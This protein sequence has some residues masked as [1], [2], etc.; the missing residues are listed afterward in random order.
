MARLFNTT[1]NTKLKPPSAHPPPLTTY[2]PGTGRGLREVAASAWPEHGIRFLV[3][4]LIRG[5]VVHTP[6]DWPIVGPV[7]PVGPSVGLVS[8]L[9]GL[10]SPSVGLMSSLARCHSFGILSSTS[11]RNERGAPI[12]WVASDPRS[13]LIPRHRRCY[14]RRGPPAS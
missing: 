5:V 9:V 4:L 11:W 12:R 13:A 8:P 7:Q 3:L 10:M 6:I 1:S 2:C 14:G